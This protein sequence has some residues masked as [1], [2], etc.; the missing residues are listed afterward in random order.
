MHIDTALVS[1][2]DWTVTALAVLGIAA[3][4]QAVLIIRAC[5]MAFDEAS[6]TSEDVV[7][8]AVETGAAI[9]IIRTSAIIVDV[10]PGRRGGRK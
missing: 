3:P 8:C 6:T 9:G 4:N 2:D 10:T 7:V 5:G 1:F